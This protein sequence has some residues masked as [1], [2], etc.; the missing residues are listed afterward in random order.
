MCTA[1]SPFISKRLTNCPAGYRVRG[2]SLRY[3][4]SVWCISGCP[5][6]SFLD[7]IPPSIGLV[8]LRIWRCAAV[9]YGKP[10][11]CACLRHEM[12]M[13]RVQRGPAAYGVVWR[14]RESDCNVPFV[15]HDNGRVRMDGEA[16]KKGPPKSQNSRLSF[17][18]FAFVRA[19][20]GQ[21]AFG[22]RIW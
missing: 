3:A 4:F 16:G 2:N 11:P 10:P 13:Y 17:Y 5:T 15:H 12:T 1:P 18:A 14:W 7:R 22:K 20:I 8:V 9:C 6:N 21:N 19:T